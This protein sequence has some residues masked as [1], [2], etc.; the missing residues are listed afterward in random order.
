MLRIQ[1]KTML[2]VQI[3]MVFRYLF[4]VKVYVIS[5]SVSRMR[6]IDGHSIGY[7]KIYDMATMLT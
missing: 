7:E 1:V 6:Y 5:D 2:G 4:M 3:Y